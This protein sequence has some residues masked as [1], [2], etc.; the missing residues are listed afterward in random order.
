MIEWHALEQYLELAKQGAAFLVV[1]A[2]SEAE[3]TRVMNVA[4]RFDLRLAAKYGRITVERL[5]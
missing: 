2:P 4:R 5:L 1:Y 3:T